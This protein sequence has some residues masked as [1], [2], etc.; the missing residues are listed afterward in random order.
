MTWHVAQERLA[1]LKRAVMAEEEI[2]AKLQAQLREDQAYLSEQ[3]EVLSGLASMREAEHAAELKV[4]HRHHVERAL[5]PLH[6]RSSAAGRQIY[7]QLN[8]WRMSSNLC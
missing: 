6:N 5:G 3:R 7:M 2:T 8:S 4:S 1:D